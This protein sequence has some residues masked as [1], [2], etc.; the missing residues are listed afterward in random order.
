MMRSVLVSVLAAAALQGTVFQAGAQSAPGKDPEWW[1]NSG[2]LGIKGSVPARYGVLSGKLL[3]ESTAVRVGEADLFAMAAVEELDTELAQ[4]GGSG[5]ELERL[6]QALRDDNGGTDESAR[7]TMGELKVLMRPFYDRLLHLGYYGPP[8]STGTAMTSG[9]YP[10]VRSAPLGDDAGTVTFGQLKHMFSF[11]VKYSSAGDGTP[12]WWVVKYFGS[13]RARLNAKAAVPWSGGRVTYLEAYEKGL[14]PIR[15]IYA[16]RPA[17]AMSGGDNQTGPKGG[18][19]PFPVQVTVTG[20]DG[21]PLP[22]AP[23]TFSVPAGDGEFQRSSVDK[24]MSPSETVVT[25]S[26]GLAKGFYQ[27]PDK[28]NAKFTITVTAGSDREAAVLHFTEYS[29]EGKGIG[30]NGEPYCSPF[31]PSDLIGTINADGSEDMTWQNNTDPSDK[32]PIPLWYWDTK[33]KTW[34]QVT[35]VPAGTTSYH[36]RPNPTPMPGRMV[37]KQ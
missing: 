13:L 8:L 12:D 20:A 7:I 31:D 11:D 18:L 9:T 35:S 19:V 5:A 32:T 26:A 29:D 33:T 23:V 27:L 36:M 4:F 25:D 37:D 15:Y 3:K 28:A 10:W 34:F 24:T 21:N 1:T 22:D 16:Q 14:N 6:A 2:I 17:L 30:P